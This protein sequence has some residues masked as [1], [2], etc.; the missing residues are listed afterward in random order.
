MQDTL[1]RLQDLVGTEIGVSDWLQ[2]DQSRID[3]F[4]DATLDH[5]W[6]HVDPE[7]AAQGPFGTTIAHGFLTLSLTVHLMSQIELDMGEPKMAINYGLDR[8]RFTA[9]VPTGSRIRGRVDLVSVDEAG[10]GIQVKRKVT[11]E[12]EGEERPAMIA[13]SLSRY[14][15]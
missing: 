12:I 15:Y 10:G 9:P 13:E 7:R 4:A 3:A 2:I 14:Y 11:V 8:V 1:Q 5:Q 6:I